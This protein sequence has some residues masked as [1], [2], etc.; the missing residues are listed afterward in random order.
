MCVINYN[1]CNKY[2]PLTC[3]IRNITNSFKR[4]NTPIMGLMMFF[5]R[6]Y[7]GLIDNPTSFSNR[8]V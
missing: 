3:L 7:N 4:A 6:N 5:I 1:I 8:I 2:Q